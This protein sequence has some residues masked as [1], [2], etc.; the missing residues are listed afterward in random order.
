MHEW[1]VPLER[2]LA[3]TDRCRSP[4]STPLAEHLQSQR[5]FARL[6][7]SNFSDKL[8]CKLVPAVVLAEQQP[9]VIVY[10]CVARPR[11]V[12][13]AHAAAAICRVAA[14]ASV[15]WS[16]PPLTRRAATP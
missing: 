9:I 1:V 6:H 12:A 15:S 4:R 3:A 10:A 14:P 11:G 7:P 5:Y 2:D 16:L 8:I 13:P